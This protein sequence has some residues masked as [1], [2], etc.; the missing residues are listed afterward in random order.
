MNTYS[1]F[2]NRIAQRH[3]YRAYRLWAR[4]DHMRLDG[5]LYAAA[6]DDAT[7]TIHAR[8]AVTFYRAAAAKDPIRELLLESISGANNE[9]PTHGGF[10]FSEELLYHRLLIT[11]ALIKK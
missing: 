8:T 2:Y 1:A 4:A 10:S 7:A 9:A 11:S 3:E 6:Q 5:K